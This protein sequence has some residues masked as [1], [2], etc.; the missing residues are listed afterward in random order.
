MPPPLKI[1][2]VLNNVGAFAT[3]RLPFGEYL[4]AHGHQVEVFVGQDGSAVTDPWGEGVIKAAGIKVTKLQFETQGLNPRRE[5][6]GVLALKRALQAYDPDIVHSVSPKGNVYA[7]LALRLMPP[8]PIVFA[9]SGLG[10]IFTKSDQFSVKQLVVRG[11]YKLMF[12]LALRQKVRRVLVQNSEDLGFMQENFGIPDVECAMVGGVG[13]DTDI[14]CPVPETQPPTV[15]FPARVLIDK[16]AREFFQ[17]AQTLKIRYPEWRFL[18]CGSSDY[19]NPKAVSSDELAEWQASGTIEFAGF[20]TDMQPI[21]AQSSIVCL[22]SYR[23]GFPRV[24]MEAAACGLPVVSTTV[25]GCRDAVLPDQT[26]F[27]VAPKDAVGLTE[28]LERLI[29]SPEL[30]QRLG[31]AGRALALERFRDAAIHDEIFG[32]YKLLLQR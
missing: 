10:Y 27:L 12:R 29:M 24:L 9:I 17:A 15:L 22:P 2:F 32:L 13:V 18:I 20:Q 8:R 5:G 11:I 28:A 31:A 26:G 1:A 25:P 14:L 19:Q 30:R 3:H 7:G 23:E 6:N 16:G 4:V 21:Y